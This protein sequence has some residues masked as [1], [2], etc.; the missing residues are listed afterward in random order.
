MNQE[1][2]S[3]LPTLVVGAVGVVFGDIG[4]SPL[5]TVKEILNPAHGITLD[6][7]NVLG[8]LSLVFWSLILVVSLKY[9]VFIMRADNRGEGGI[10]AL[11]ALAQQAVHQYPRLRWIFL[12]LGIFG[13]AL[14]YGDGIITPAISVLSAIEGLQI[15]TP[16]LADFVIPLA[17]AVLVGLFVIQRWGTAGVGIFFGPIMI[18][19]F[20]VLGIMGLAQIIH[21]PQV[22]VAL[23]PLYGLHFFSHN[24]MAG[25]LALG[26]VVLAVTGAEALYADMGHFGKR[27]IR[28]AWSSLTLPALLLNY[29]GQGALILNNP[30]A[31]ENPFY[32]LAPSWALFPLI[33]LA[34][35]ATVIA[36][37]AVISGAFSITRQAIQLG[38]LPRMRV[39][40]TSQSEIGQVYIPFINVML[41]VGVASLVLVLRNSS[42]LAAAY[43]IAVTGTMAI[44]T[45]LASL[46]AY[47]IWNRNIW[48]VAALAS[49]FLCVDLTFFAANVPK[50]P[51]GGW[52]PLV[53][54]VAMFT[55]L[56]TWKKGRELLLARQT[57]EDLALEP[58]LKQLLEYPPTRVPG[59]AVF[60]TTSRMTVPHALFHNLLHNKVLHERVVFL[61]VITEEIPNVPEHERVQ[62]N[63]LGQGAWRVMVRYG[64]KDEPDIPRAL[65]LCGAHGLTFYMMET[66]FFLNRETILPSQLPGMALWREHLFAWMSRSAESAMQFFNIPP[67]RVI[68]LGTQVEI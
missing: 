12:S 9:V 26:S 54:G 60:L 56:S 34:T 35:A 8:M 11:I 14:F 30:K 22:L 2:K 4:T 68:E 20:I 51:H 55:V 45:L 38:Y 67:N 59:T 21:M 62:I 10:M 32:F 47:A 17:L 41:A 61:T 27:A 58:F 31:M 49:V 64:F 52:F 46:V 13:A 3:A 29:F 50:I 16:R 19:W 24:G 7:V 48:G 36:S 6:T 18:L 37:Q 25:F 43:G 57:T 39:L 15:A 66:S 42:N 23:N 53:I 5:Y 44:D 28:I 63:D 40:H 33:V 1:N 65:E